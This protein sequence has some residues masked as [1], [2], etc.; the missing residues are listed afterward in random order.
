[1]SIKDRL[2]VILTKIV[3]TICQNKTEIIATYG[4]VIVETYTYM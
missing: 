1:M 3:D 2:P 4:Q